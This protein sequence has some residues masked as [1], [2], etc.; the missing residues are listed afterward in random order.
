MLPFVVEIEEVVAE[1]VDEAFD[2]TARE[3]A[4]GEFGAK[5]VAV[6]LVGAGQVHFLGWRLMSSLCLLAENWTRLQG[7]VHGGDDG[8]PGGDAVL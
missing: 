1:L 5:F 8:L 4:A 6:L 7:L 3:A 2:V